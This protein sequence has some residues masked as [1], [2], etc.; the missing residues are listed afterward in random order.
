MTF[1]PVVLGSG[2]GGYAYLQRT[3]EAQQT[4][5]ERDP[6]VTRE[7]RKFAEKLQDVQTSEQLMA[8]RSLLTVALGAFGLGEDL[9]NR[10]FIKRI[11]D[12][13]LTDTQSL[14][15]RLADKRYLAFAQAFNFSG[16]GGPRLPDAATPGELSARLDQLQDA[17][18]L[19]GDRALLRASLEQ[20]GL[21]DNINNTYFL[22]QVL[23][24]DLSDANSFANRMPDTRLVDFARTFDFFQKGIA[25]EQDKPRLDRVVEGFS[26]NFGAINTTE[27]L[28]AVPGLLTEALKVFGLDNIYTPAFLGDVLNSDLT[29]RTSFANTQQDKRFA[30]F[31][32]AFNFATPQRDTFGTAQTDTD[33][34]PVMRPGKLQTFV[35]AAGAASIETPDDF[36]DDISLRNATLD[37]LGIPNTTTNRGI[38]RRILESDPASPTALINVTSD[39]RFK[40]L[41]DLFDF[42]P[43]VAAQRTYP[44]GFV[45]QVTQN[46]LD[47]EFETRVGEID[48]AMRIALSLERELGQ[49]ARTGSNNDAK[50]F[51]IMASP[52]LRAVFEG[53]FRLP[54]SFGSIDVDQQLSRLKDRAERTF[55]TSEVS[56]FTD[57]KRLDDLR[58]RYLL[59]NTA[60]DLGVSSGANIASLVLSSLSR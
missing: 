57:P 8:D 42:K 43:A 51:S 29:D 10:A 18:D 2:L 13:D 15:N 49:V 34:N 40:A 46:Y 58:Q 52:P 60:Q 6:V 31:A 21:E 28:L 1:S 22:R 33:G 36:F 35:A 54:S 14:A 32:A 44:D 53:A 12:S 11:L 7:T 5:F 26:G 19:L 56:D 38:A 25:A 50:W 16:E 45:E 59:F 30:A 47:R 48:P 27:K 4:L 20:F 3:R 37:L 23:N 41:G 24:S 17:D 39:Q 55:G 9:G